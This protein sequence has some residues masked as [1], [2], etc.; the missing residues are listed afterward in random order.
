MVLA[1]MRDDAQ[2]ERHE[3]VLQHLPSQTQQAWIPQYSLLVIGLPQV[4]CRDTSRYAEM[5]KTGVAAHHTKIGH[6]GTD[7]ILHIAS[8]PVDEQP[9]MN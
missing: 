9:A 6:V 5:Q 8:R 7:L 2:I 3:Y 4:V 1:E